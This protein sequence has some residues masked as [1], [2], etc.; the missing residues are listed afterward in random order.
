MLGD[1][2][3][4]PN[5]SSILLGARRNIRPWQRN[6]KNRPTPGPRT[7]FNLS[8]MLSQNRFANAQSQTRAASRPLGRV[9]RIEDIG[10]DLGSDSRPV[11]LK[12]DRNR[13]TGPFQTNPQGAQFP[14]LAHRL[15]GIQNEIEENLHELM[16]VAVDHG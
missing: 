13:L 10:Q 5:P 7:S 2:G 3:G 16:R 1:G 6:F 8:T 4:R 15:F 9:E 14:G 11:V 12:R